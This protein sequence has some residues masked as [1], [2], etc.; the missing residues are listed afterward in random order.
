MNQLEGI[1]DNFQRVKAVIDDN[2]I[3]QANLMDFTTLNLLCYE[4]PL[5][6]EDGN[7]KWH[8][9][10][11]KQRKG[12][13]RREKDKAISNSKKRKVDYYK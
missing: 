10:K 1:Y 4:E 11:R 2:E 7:A 13:K 9:R 8:K 6:V 12:K 5:R 3:T